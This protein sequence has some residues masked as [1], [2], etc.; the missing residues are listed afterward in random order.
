MAAFCLTADFVNKF[1]QGLKNGQIDPFKMST[2]TSDERHAFLEDWVGK[3]NA[4]QVNALFESKLLLKNQQTGLINWAKKTSGM[5]PNAKRDI[6]SRIEKMDTILNPKNEDAFLK[7]LASTKL[8]T[9]VTHE[10]AQQIFD[11]SQKIKDA[12]AKVQEEPTNKNRDQM[13]LEIYNMTKLLDKITPTNKHILA[14]IVNL[15]HAAVAS[16]DFSEFF[17]HGFFSMT[18]PAWIKNIIKAPGIA[19]SEKQF[20]KRMGQIY[21]NKYYDNLTKSGL[22]I[23][24]VSGDLSKREENFA[25]TFIDKLPI[26]KGSQRAYTGFLNGLRIDM[27]SKMMKGAELRGDD[28]SVNSRTTESIVKA[29]NDLT[30]ASRLPGGMEHAANEWATVLFSPRMQVSRFNMINPYTYINPKYTLESRVFQLKNLIGS[31]SVAVSVLAVAGMAGLKIGTNSQK[32]DFGE[33]HIGNSTIDVTGGNRTLITLLSRIAPNFMGGGKYIS[34]A[35]K[36]TQLG[37][38]SYK[39]LT[40]LDLAVSYG[41][42]KLAPGAA[43]MLA[44]FLDQ[45]N[46]KN[47]YG[48]KVDI[49]TELKKQL[50]PLYIADAMEMYDNDPSNTALAMTLGLFGI[51]LSSS[52]KQATQADWTSSTSSQIKQFQSKVSSDKFNQANQDYNNLLQQRTQKIQKDPRFINLSPTEQQK[53]ITKLK[54]KVQS[55]IFKQY[56]FR[57]RRTRSTN[58]RTINSLVQ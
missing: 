47:P 25:S 39:P 52:N 44:D 3:D 37:I 35:G 10:E 30:G 45:S 14:N 20:D 31:A 58:T 41:I 34:N 13:G 49:P 55:T 36:V 29:V 24:K 38:G 5:S 51:S 1:K 48:E 23:F 33:I 27:A 8:G 43:S 54:S 12:K 2:M 7:D 17:K 18:N 21:G 46:G 19:Y 26:F 56:N 53:T 11:Q 15:P 57:Y 42:G 32:T 28:I 22:H 4:K 40:R 16:L 50:T 6:I 9:D